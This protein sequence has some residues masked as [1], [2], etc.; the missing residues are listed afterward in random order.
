MAEKPSISD[1]YKL[2]ISQSLQDAVDEITSNS[3]LVTAT[4]ADL[5]DNKKR[6]LVVGICLHSIIAPALR[7]YIAPILSDLYN[8]LNS[9]HKIDT[10]IYPTHLEKYPP[11]HFPLNY[12]AVNNNKALYRFQKAKC[13]YTIK[14][15]V[16]LSKLFLLTHMAQYTGF[17]ETC[18]TS[19][20][21]ELVISIDKFAPALRS[22]AVEL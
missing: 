4:P 12:E 22:D 9:Y 17:D 3:P 18:E 16:D 7:N 5:D 8:E 10:Q 13:N 1:N 21:L 14:H 6:W 2:P 20:L 19:A 11:T 15:A